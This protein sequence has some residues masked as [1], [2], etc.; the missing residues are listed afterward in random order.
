LT[1]SSQRKEPSFATTPVAKLGFPLRTL[2]Q[3]L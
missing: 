2:R 3:S 1:Q